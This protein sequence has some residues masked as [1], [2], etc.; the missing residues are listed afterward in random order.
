MSLVALD[1]KRGERR[2]PRDVIDDPAPLLDLNL[3][4]V[5]KA[6]SKGNDGGDD[7]RRNN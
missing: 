5:P 3:T 7:E 4:G 1:P 6:P 2:P